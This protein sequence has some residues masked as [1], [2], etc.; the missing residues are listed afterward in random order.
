MI[1]YRNTLITLKRYHQRLSGSLVEFDLANYQDI[2]NRINQRQ[3]TLQK[4]SD[5]DLKHL[6]YQISQD[7]RRNT[8]EEESLVPAFALVQETVKRVLGL[9]PFDVQLIGGMVLH[10]GKLAE[11]KTGEGKTLTAVF[12]AYLNALSGMGVHILTFNDYL[13]RRDAGWM[14]P[15]FEFLGLRVG[16]VQEG[17]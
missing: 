16:Y 3:S 10:D 9:S 1:S 17:M 14:G 11:M 15:V 5:K 7:I 2:L 6:S 8:S 4:K 12:P 13:A